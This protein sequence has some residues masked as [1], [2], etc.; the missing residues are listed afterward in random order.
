MTTA[1]LIIIT[2]SRTVTLARHFQ[3]PTRT[4][5]SPSQLRRAVALV[6][7]VT[8]PTTTPA[9][10]PGSSLLP[11][12]RSPNPRRAGRMG[13]GTAV[14]RWPGWPL[15]KPHFF[16]DDSEQMCLSLVPSR[17]QPTSP[18]H[19]ADE[20]FSA[21]LLHRADFLGRTSLL[22][23]SFGPFCLSLFS[24]PLDSSSKSLQCV[25]CSL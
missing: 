25:Q 16:L 22:S 2:D 23:P 15:H 18:L 19:R 12:C 17:Q 7:D 20:P 21:S 10:A 14:R 13:K 6:P 3:S 8:P 4:T 9:P 24:M 1:T 11:W 5:E